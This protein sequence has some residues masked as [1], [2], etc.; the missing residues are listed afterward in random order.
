MGNIHL[1][2]GPVAETEQTVP[3]PDY[4]E[5]LDQEERQVYVQAQAA[6]FVRSTAP[7]V[8]EVTEQ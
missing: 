2:I 3:L 1:K 5:E 6:D 4:W 8:V 7:V